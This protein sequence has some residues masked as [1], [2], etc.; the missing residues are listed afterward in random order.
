MGKYRSE[1]MRLVRSIKKEVGSVDGRCQ[2]SGE[3]V[4][5]EL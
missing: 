4:R 2:R 1:D 5:I 3:I